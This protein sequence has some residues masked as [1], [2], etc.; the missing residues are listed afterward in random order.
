MTFEQPVLGTK[1]VIFRAGEM[2]QQVKNPGCSVKWL[3]L[4]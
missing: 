3:L 2:A 4:I 1:A